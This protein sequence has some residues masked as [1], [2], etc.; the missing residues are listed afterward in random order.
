M[1][2][3]AALKRKHDPHLIYRYISVLF[4]PN[5]AAM[6]EG[7]GGPRFKEKTLPLSYFDYS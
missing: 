2:G 6:P 4:T 1:C 3:V 7:L 5:G